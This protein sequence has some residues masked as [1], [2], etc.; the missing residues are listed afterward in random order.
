MLLVNDRCFSAIFIKRHIGTLR[1]CV[2][3]LKVKHNMF[4][5]IIISVIC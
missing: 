5:L 1:N 2:F 4:L 3:N